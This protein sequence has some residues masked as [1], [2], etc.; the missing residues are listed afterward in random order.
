MLV[1]ANTMADVDMALNVTD[2]TSKRRWSI[3]QHFEEEQILNSCAS[4]AP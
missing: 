4:W 1:W 2:I 3:S